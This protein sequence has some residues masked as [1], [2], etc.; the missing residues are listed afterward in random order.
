MSELEREQMYREIGKTLPAG[1]VGEVDDIAQAYLYL[2][3]QPYS[4]GTVLTLDGG[5]ILI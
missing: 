5:T 4:T 3:T 2:I 1:R